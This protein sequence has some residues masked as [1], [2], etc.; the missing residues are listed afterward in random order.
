MSTNL[1]DID[2]KSLIE[3]K[4]AVSIYE[5]DMK[6]TATMP[7]ICNYCYD[8]GM[9]HA[10]ALL[11]GNDFLP[12][13]V[14]FVITRFQARIE[15]YPIFG[16][17]VLIRSW[18]SP[19]ES[20][21]VVRNYLLMDES[22]EIIGRAINSATTFNLKKRAGED[23]SAHFDDAKF[24]ALNLEPALPHVF[25][26]IPDVV[27]PDYVNNVDV[28]YFD[29]D[30]YQ[31]VNNVKY[32][33]WC[34]ETMPIEFIKTHRLYEVDINYRREASLGERLVAKTCTAPE[35]DVFIHSITSEDGTRDILRMKSV[36]K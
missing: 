4:Y 29:C 34:I 17:N 2:D 7:A 10:T 32:T 36:W 6:Y 25:E 14:V 35:E 15:R 19:V 3:K 12:K 18:L 9:T 24:K 13:D 16:E 26:K 22:G 33:E 30:F 11:K 5:M 28:R 20:K 1:N 23:L 27:S 31:H 8:V 21:H